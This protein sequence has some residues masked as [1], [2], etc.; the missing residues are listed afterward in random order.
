VQQPPEHLVAWGV[1]GDG[2]A[3]LLDHAGVVTAQH[4]RELVLG[5]ALEVAG[6]DEGVDRVDRGRLHPDQQLVGANLGGGQVLA[7]PGWGVG[8]V[9]GEGAH[10]V[11]LS[12][13]TGHRPD[14]IAASIIWPD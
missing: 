8:A 9:Q 11:V 14:T 5:H 10:R 6:G 7:Q 1:A 4:D 13:E 12:E 2:R 3:D